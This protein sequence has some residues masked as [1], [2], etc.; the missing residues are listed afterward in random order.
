M[1]TVKDYPGKEL[2]VYNIDNLGSLVCECIHVVCDDEDFGYW[3]VFASSHPQDE[4]GTC[5]I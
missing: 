3:E 2:S 5:A 1:Y 4:F